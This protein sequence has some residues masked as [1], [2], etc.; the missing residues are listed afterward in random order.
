MPFPFFIYSLMES[1]LFSGKEAAAWGGRTFS[2]APEHARAGATEGQRLR[3][4]FG[5]LEHA[6]F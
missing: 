2:G 5:V 4:F 6:A 1:V 3:H